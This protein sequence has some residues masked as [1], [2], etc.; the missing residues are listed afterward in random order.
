LPHASPGAGCG[1]NCANITT[2]PFRPAAHARAALANIAAA[3]RF[4]S[5]V[6]RLNGRYYL[7]LPEGLDPLWEALEAEDDPFPPSRA[8]DPGDPRGGVSSVTPP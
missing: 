2:L 5:R 8:G 1:N 3:A 6:V 4:E 7:P